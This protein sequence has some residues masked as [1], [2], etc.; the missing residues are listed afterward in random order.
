MAIQVTVSYGGQVVSG[1]MLDPA[2]GRVSLDL[3]PLPAETVEAVLQLAPQGG[4]DLGG[5][6]ASCISEWVR[7]GSARHMGAVTEI[8][9]TLNASNV[10]G[11]RDRAFESTLY[12]SSGAG[13]LRIGL[14]IPTLNVAGAAAPPAVNTAPA[15]APTPGP[16][17]APPPTVGAAPNVPFSTPPPATT[18]AAPAVPAPAPPPSAAW[19][20]SGTP[21]YPPGPAAGIPP[22]Y[23]A[24][25]GVPAPQVVPGRCYVHPDV[26]TPLVCNRCRNPFCSQ[27]LVDIR[28]ASYCGWCKGAVLY[29]MQRRP[30]N[31]VDIKQVLFWAKVYN[32]LMALG[33]LAGIAFQLLV[34]TSFSEIT[35]AFRP[36]NPGSEIGMIVGFVL[37]VL[38]LL[39]SVPPMLG[40]K[41]GQRWAYIWE[42]ILLLPS[43]F[44]SCFWLSCF[45]FFF[46]PGA[47]ALFVYWMKPEVKAYFEPSPG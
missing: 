35:R 39:V 10:Y 4:E 47:I 20:A 17:V 42:A 46:W 5:P 13:L 23:P 45:S 1:A 9:L 33:G 8:Q 27:C 21:A 40:M 19:G 26:E 38:A 34:L 3:P 14:R 30:T 37:P 24:Q 6:S 25:Q 18:P 29:D 2:Q 16:A 22:S 41:P 44:F 43:A 32:G 28:G 15:A 36:T 7:C 12:L 11:S 31:T